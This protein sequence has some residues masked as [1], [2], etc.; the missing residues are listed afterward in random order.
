MRTGRAPAL[1][2]LAALTTFA[3]AP[4]A[5]APRPLPFGHSCAP[6]DGALS[7]TAAPPPAGEA[8]ERHVQREGV[9]AQERTADA[10]AP[11]ALSAASPVAAASPSAVRTA[12]SRNGEP[13]CIA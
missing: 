2:A 6:L 8:V 4:T 10:G 5:P 12:G 3:L 11:P 7:C 9:T 13:A 1:S